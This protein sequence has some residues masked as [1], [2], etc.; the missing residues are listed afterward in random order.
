MYHETIDDILLR[1]NFH[2]CS[3]SQTNQTSNGSKTQSV[4][5]CKSN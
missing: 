5:G 2:V 3:G 4:M 1:T